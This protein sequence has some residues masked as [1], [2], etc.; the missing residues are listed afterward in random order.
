MFL[1][2]LEESYE[3]YRLN[4]EESAKLLSKV[5]TPFCIPAGR[6]LDFVLLSSVRTL[7]VVSSN[8]DAV[9]SLC[10]PVWPNDE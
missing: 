1:F 2:L 10:G 4:F 6:V 5:I 8:E 3:K 7:G 9:V